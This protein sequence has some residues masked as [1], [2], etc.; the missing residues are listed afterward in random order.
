MRAL[1]AD[2]LILVEERV[3]R[4]VLSERRGIRGRS[5]KAA[6]RRGE[7]IIAKFCGEEKRVN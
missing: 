7:Q 6:P 5:G 3:I 1:L 2:D 4:V